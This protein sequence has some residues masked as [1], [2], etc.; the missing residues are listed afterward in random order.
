DGLI[1][2]RPVEPR[3]AARLLV[4]DRNDPA[5]A[6]ERA[7][8]DLPR[9]LREGDLL[10]FNDSRVL[11]ARLVGVRRASGGRVGGLFLVEHPGPPAPPAPPVRWEVLLRSNGR[12]RPGDVIDLLGAHGEATSVSLM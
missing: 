4:V 11:P 7:V 8:R 12:L 3:D 9:I 10:V 5:H 6:E 2:T 1:A